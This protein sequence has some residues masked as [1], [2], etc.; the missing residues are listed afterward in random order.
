[1][2]NSGGESSGGKIGAKGYGCLVSIFGLPLVLI[3]LFIL[4][5]MWVMTSL[6]SC[7]AE[8]V[9]SEILGVD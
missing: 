5:L 1:M 9:L 3:A 6:M 8:V 7:G 4:I 2:K